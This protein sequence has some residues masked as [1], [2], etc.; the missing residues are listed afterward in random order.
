MF[1]LS[2]VLV[3]RRLLLA[4]WLNFVSYDVEEI[5]IHHRQSFK[6]AFDSINRDMM[7]AILQHYGIPNNI[8]SAIRVLYDQSTNQVY[9]LGKRSE[10]LAITTGIVQGDLLLTFLYIIVTYDH[11]NRFVI[12][13]SKIKSS[14]RQGPGA[15]RTTYL[16][17]I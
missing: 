3:L 16:N 7:F 15:P 6:K 2:L 12:Y 8:V 9:L 14:L 17:Q 1:R 4:V 10:P 5:P 13:E 11:A